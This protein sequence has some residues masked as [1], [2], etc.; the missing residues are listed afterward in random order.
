MGLINW[1]GSGVV[2]AS[3]GRGISIQHL[4]VHQSNNHVK[5]RVEWLY[6][7]DIHCNAFFPL[8]VLLY[9]VQFFL[10]PFVLSKSFFALFISNTLYA[11]AFSLYF[12]ISHLGYRAL[13][14]L[15]NTEIF[16]FPIA[17]VLF[18]YALNLIGYPFG[19]GFNA[20][21]IVAYLY[22]D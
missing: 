16:L 22:F 10:L 2:L 1:F 17:V 7:F 6:A 11:V 19:M 5:Q 14:F 3:V 15:C 12:Y 18:I 8:F 20:S 4:T 13:P 21:R 9:V